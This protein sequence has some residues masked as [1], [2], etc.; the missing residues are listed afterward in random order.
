M[1]KEEQED[2]AA[3]LKQFYPAEKK[4]EERL[5]LLSLQIAKKVGYPKVP[6]L[7]AA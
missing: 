6:W 2:F 4:V 7:Y 3:D 1:T 5:D